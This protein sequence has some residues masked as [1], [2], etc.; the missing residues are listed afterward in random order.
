MCSLSQL[1]SVRTSLCQLLHQPDPAAMRAE[2]GHYADGALLGSGS[3]G[4]SRVAS[5]SARVSPRQNASTLEEE[6]PLPAGRG[7]PTAKPSGRQNNGRAKAARAP[8]QRPARGDAGVADGFY[9]CMY[10]RSAARYKL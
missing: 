8:R 9:S 7:R 3:R 10:P 4:A 6:E 2:F 1:S 5:P